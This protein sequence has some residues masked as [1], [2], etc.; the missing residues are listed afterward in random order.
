MLRNNV[1]EWHPFIAKNG[2]TGEVGTKDE[3]SFYRFDT[4]ADQV[5]RYW[6]ERVQESAGYESVYTV[7]M[8][9][10][11]DDAMVGPKTL[12]EKVDLMGRIIGSQQEILIENLKRK[13]ES[14]PQLFCPYKE[15]L[16]IYRAGLKLPPEIT[17]LWPDD[18]HGYLRQLSTP[19]EQKRSGRSGVYYHLSYWGAPADYLWLCSTSPGLIAF[20][21]QKALAAG[22]DRLWVFNVGDLKP[23]EM[24]TE[25]AMD[26]AWEPS[27]WTSDTAPQYARA[28]AARTFGESFA[29]EIA[30]IKDEYYT[31]A[32]M[33]KPEHVWLISYSRSEAQKRLARYADLADRAKALARKIPASLQDAYFQLVLYPVSGACKMNE[34]VLGAKLGKIDL[35]NDAHK[36]IQAMTLTYN[37]KVAGGQWRNIMD[38]QPRQ[39][40]AFLDPEAL[41]HLQLKSRNASTGCPALTAD[42]AAIEIDLSRPVRTHDAPQAAITYWRG[43]GSPHSVGRIP[44]IGPAYEPDSAPW[45]QYKVPVS[46]GNQILRIRFLPTHAI[47]TAL[48]LRVATAIDQNPD[49]ISS[50]DTREFSSNWSVNV[51]QGFAEVAIPHSASGKGEIT[52]RISLLDPG[53]VLTSVSV[54]PADPGNGSK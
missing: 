50:I 29:D 41:L 46:V 53:V 42:S 49:K 12:P 22:A 33:G 25:F 11:H 20:E 13:S 34:K 9:G 32:Q 15:V 28:W 27:R 23:A 16:E 52:L 54:L 1:K 24:E 4:N 44:L 43:L 37:E 8:R 17:L 2:R 26:L 35:A 7:G 18:N 5:N 40:P 3:N 21:M 39:Q 51:L 10:V 6:R 30:G 19:E 38:W 47:N 45:V 36:E 48:G 31:L 14:I